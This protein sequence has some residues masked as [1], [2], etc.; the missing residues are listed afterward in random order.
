MRRYTKI[1]GEFLATIFDVDYLI[2]YTVDLDDLHIDYVYV[3]G[4]E[5]EYLNLGPFTIEAIFD[6]AR[7]HYNEGGAEPYVY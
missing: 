7:D 5:I 2:G 6:Q 1:G 3:D 4:R